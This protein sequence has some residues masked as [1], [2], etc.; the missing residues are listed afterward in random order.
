VQQEEEIDEERVSALQERRQ[1]D[2]I[3]DLKTK[4]NYWT[5]HAV[6]NNLVK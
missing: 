5:P 4:L 1:N 3:V 2:Y 6:P